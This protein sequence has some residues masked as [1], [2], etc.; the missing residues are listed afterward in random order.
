MVFFKLMKR[1]MKPPINKQQKSVQM[2]KKGTDMKKH[3]GNMKPGPMLVPKLP[4]R[5][6][7]AAAGGGGVVVV[8]VVSVVGVEIRVEES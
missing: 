7:V 5:V 6:G 1:Y 2:G 3:H 4:S 8:V